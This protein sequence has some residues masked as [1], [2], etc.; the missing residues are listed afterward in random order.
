VPFRS[1]AVL[2]VPLVENGLELGHFSKKYVKYHQVER[3]GT[4]G[5]NG[6]IL[7]RSTEL[8]N[9]EME[10]LWNLSW[11]GM[12]G[13]GTPPAPFVLSYFHTLVSYYPPVAALLII[14]SS[15]NPSLR[16]R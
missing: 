9:T 10:R 11:N 3:N 8:W 12:K 4:G 5:T 1:N 15:E 16:Q 6:T 2:P 13:T 7:E 14:S